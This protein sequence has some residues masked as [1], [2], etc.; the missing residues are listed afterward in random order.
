MRARFLHMADCHLGYRQY[1]VDERFNDFGRALLHVVNIAIEQRVDFVLLAGDL[2]HKRAIDA[3]TLNQAIHALERLR[4]AQIPCLAVEGNHE[5]AYVDDYMGWLHFLNVRGYLQLLEAGYENGAPIFVPYARGKGAYADP[6]PWL[7]VYGMGFRGAGTARAVEGYAAALQAEVRPEIAYTV[8]MTHAG[9]EGEV[10][11]TSGLS[12]REWAPLRGQVDYVALG[13]IHKPYTREDWLYNPG[14]LETCSAA[15]VSWPERGYFLVEVDAARADGPKHQVTLHKV[16]RRPF[17]RLHLKTDLITSPELLYAQ[18]EEMMN[19]RARDLGPA[20]LEKHAR[21][22]VDLHLHGVLAFDRSGLDLSRLEQMAK[23]RLNALHALI[24]N[25]AHSADYAV[26]PGMT[27]NRQTLERNVL[28]DLF[29]RDARYA[30]RS[31]QWARLA[32]DIKALT[33]DG[34]GPEAIVDE[35]EERLARMTAADSPDTDSLDTDSP[36]TDISGADASGADTYEADAAQ[37]SAEAHA[38]S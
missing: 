36:D 24:T 37:E 33:L 9:I 4:V 21:P 32:L 12:M 5:L 19:R 3:K 29:R 8:F 2:F 7:R 6:L 15:E 31:R 34:A 26:E 13:H 16:P 17:V 38:D 10:D 11:G 18:V 20:R 28:A 35:L 1:N 30:G 14:S 25:S 23:E 22:V 27:Q